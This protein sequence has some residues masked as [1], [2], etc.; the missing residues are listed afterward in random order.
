MHTTKQAK[1]QSLQIS[2]HFNEISKLT[3]SLDGKEK[4]IT[5]GFIKPFTND[6]NTGGHSLRTVEIPD[7]IKFFLKHKQ[8]ITEL[9]RKNT[10][11]HFL[12]HTR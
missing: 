7:S 6:D 11:R 2:T 9:N 4:P 5:A 8:Q 10:I 3:H 1:S 12:K